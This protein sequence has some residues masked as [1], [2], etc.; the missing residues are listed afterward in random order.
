MTPL[1][2]SFVSRTASAALAALLCVPV[3]AER[4]DRFQ[5]MNIT[6]DQQGTVDLQKQV[7]VFSGNVNV[8]KGSLL[9]K[10]DRIEIRELP[11][12]SR[13]A[14]ASGGPASFRQKRDVPNESIEG[15]AD[16]LEY[17]DRSEVVRFVN[18]ATVRRLLGTTVLD[19]INGQVIR[20]ESISGV[21]SVSGAPVA[22]GGSASAPRG[23]VRAVL[24][25]RES[26]PAS[27]G[28]N[29]APKV[30]PSAFP[31]AAPSAV[32]GEKP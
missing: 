6:A 24:A 5:A 22:A 19:E 12:G 18:N 7:I 8:S 3:A 1:C 26:P 10:A 28:P 30:T 25:P 21:F 31:R 15:Q 11:D 4:A 14:L 2:L 27:E 9:I 20:Y 32:P 29:E 16:R 13:T 23:R 17:E